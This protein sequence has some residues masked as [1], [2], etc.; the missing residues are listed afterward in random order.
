MNSVKAKPYVIGI[1]VRYDDG[2]IYTLEFVRFKANGDL[3][4]SQPTGDYAKLGNGKKFD[5]HVTYH[6]DGTFHA[7]SYGNHEHRKKRQPLDAS[8]SGFENL[9][10]QP[11]GHYYAPS[12]GYLCDGFD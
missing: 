5:P 9:L 2:K 10:I 8:F 1:C 12:H 11:F 7:V 3:I 4:M 6:R